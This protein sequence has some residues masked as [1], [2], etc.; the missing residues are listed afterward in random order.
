MR[1]KIE[2]GF[3]V[4]A[5]DGQVGIGSVREVRDGELL[6]YIENSGDLV[7][8]L[9]GV[10][11]VHSGKVVLDMERLDASV[12]SAIEH[13]HDAEDPFYE[14]GGSDLRDTPGRELEPPL[15]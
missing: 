15:R 1:E 12:R 14:A 8:P 4:F 9:E 11:S 7:V 6:V 2:E 10:K 3:M 13:V 5:A